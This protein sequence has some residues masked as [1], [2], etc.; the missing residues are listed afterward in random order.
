M[1]GTFLADKKVQQRKFDNLLKIKDNYE[2]I[3]VSADEFM[4]GNYKGIK[5]KH[6]VDFLFIP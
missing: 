3:V 1:K 4:Q 6:I 5:H 2:K